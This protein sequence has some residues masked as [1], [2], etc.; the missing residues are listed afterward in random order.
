MVTAVVADLHLGSPYCVLRTPAVRERLLAEIEQAD[1]TVLL[2][3]TLTLRNTSTTDVVAAAE[4]FF[5]ELGDAV[6]ERELVVVPG[7]H[8][9]RLALPLLESPGVSELVHRTPVTQHTQGPLGALGR[10]LGRAQ[11]TV[12]YPGVWIRPDVYATHGHYLDLHAPV[13]RIDAAL[14]AAMTAIVRTPP[15]RGARVADYE[16]VLAPVYAFLHARGQSPGQPG[17]LARRGRARPFSVY[18]GGLAGALAVGA[19]MA[20]RSPNR[21]WRSLLTPAGIAAAGLSGMCEVVERIGIAARHVLFGHTH[22]AGPLPG[23]EAEWTTPGG[24]RLHNPGSWMW[25]PALI[26]DHKEA[27]PYWPGRILRVGAEGPPELRALLT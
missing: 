22:R 23:E 19:V 6:G 7:N 26:G 25:A 14:A 9:H 3:D 27:D 11:V 15:R 13:P 12:A 16:A 18:G 4:P 24:T 17:G 1:R 5:A 2:G 20:A 8:D 21:A 10:A